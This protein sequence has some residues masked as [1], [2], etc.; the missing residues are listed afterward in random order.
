MKLTATYNAPSW[1]RP[2]TL[3]T[4]CL[5]PG[6]PFLKDL[7]RDGLRCFKRLSADS[8]QEAQWE[9][10]CL[11]DGEMGFLIVDDPDREIRVS[12]D[13]DFVSLRPGETW[14]KQCGC[15]HRPRR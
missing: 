11:D 3:H 7:R 10:H 2:I 5:D 13:K 9:E 4:Y 14:S 8:G 15:I 6:S 1:A 12:E